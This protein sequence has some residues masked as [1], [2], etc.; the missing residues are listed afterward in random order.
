MDLG[1]DGREGSGMTR[2][3]MLGL[4]LAVVLLP[5]SARGTTQYVYGTG[6]ADTIRIGQVWV[7]GESAYHWYSCING[8]WTD[9]G[10][11]SSTDY[12]YIYTYGGADVIE[13]QTASGNYSCGG[14]SKYLY[15]V[16]R[17]GCPSLIRAFLGAGNDEFYGSNCGDQVWGSTEN[18]YIDGWVG[19]D[20]LYGEDGDDTIYG[21]SGLEEAFGGAGNDWIDGEGDEDVVDGGP[22]SG[23]TLYG[24]DQNDCVRD[25]TDGYITCDCGNGAADMEECSGSTTNCEYTGCLYFRTG[26]DGTLDAVP[27]DEPPDPRRRQ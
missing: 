1:E 8:S 15:V 26:P 6:G 21:Y 18:D 10:V 13:M 4:V 3:V 20:I 19:N 11:W 2:N 24:G 27:C 23:D 7:S 17:G 5:A 14:T 12:L 25:D 9:E 16:D 22:G